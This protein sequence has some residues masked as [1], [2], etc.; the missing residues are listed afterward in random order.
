MHS[1]CQRLFH[2]INVYVRNTSLVILVMKIPVPTAL[3][4]FEVLVRF[5]D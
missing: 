3:L 4:M 5:V 2:F 1:A